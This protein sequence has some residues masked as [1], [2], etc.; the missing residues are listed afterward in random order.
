MCALATTER[1]RCACSREAK[2]V[3]GALK[4]LEGENMRTDVGQAAPMYRRVRV[5]FGDHPIATY[6]A[7]P[8]LASRYELAMKRRFAG[9]RVTNDPVGLR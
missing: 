4:V 1:R 6:V 5:W 2:G 7:M 8:A 3:I 9:L